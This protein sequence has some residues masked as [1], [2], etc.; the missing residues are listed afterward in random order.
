MRKN[1]CLEPVGSERKTKETRAERS[2]S[3]MALTPAEVGGKVVAKSSGRQC[4]PA[5]RR[6]LRSAP[7]RGPCTA[8]T[9]AASG[10]LLSVDGWP[11]PVPPTSR[12]AESL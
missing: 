10:P 1:G 12:A 7:P 8:A 6:P 4:H 5:A 9:G 11:E 3:P 2:C